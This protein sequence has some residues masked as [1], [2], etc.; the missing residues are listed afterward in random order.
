MNKVYI[1]KPESGKSKRFDNRIEAQDYSID[2][3]NQ[4]KDYQRYWII[5]NVTLN[6]NKETHF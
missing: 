3:E 5:P 6:G 1:V 2:L 4:G